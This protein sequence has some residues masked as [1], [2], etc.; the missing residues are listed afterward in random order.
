[1]TEP[2]I[3]AL[4]ARRKAANITQK[5]AAAMAGISLKTYQRIEAGSSDMRLKHYGNLLKG[6]D[7]TDLDIA[8][9][10]IDIDATSMKEVTA[11]ARLLPGKARVHF[12]EMVM[13]I[14]QNQDR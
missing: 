4:T 14:Y 8:L 7:I 12:I 1:M 9:D 13:A 3:L 5:Q 10:M 11:A 2:R 6:L